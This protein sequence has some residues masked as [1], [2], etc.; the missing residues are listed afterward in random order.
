MKIISWNC[1]SVKARKEHLMLLLER[2]DPDVVL[3]QE[4]RIS[5]FPE[6]PMRYK[7]VHSE[8]IKGRNG[9]A[10]ITK[11]EMEFFTSDKEGRFIHVIINGIQF[12]CVYVP[13]GGSIS[14]SVAHKLQFF[15]YLRN[16][17]HVDSLIIGGD[18]NV[19]YK[20]NEFNMENPYTPIEQHELMYLEKYM[21]YETE[22]NLYLTWWD[23][24]ENRFNRNIGMGIDKIYCSKDLKCSPIKVLKYYRGLLLPS[25]HAPIMC[26]IMK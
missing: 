2:E 26:S 16:F 20:Q 19:L 21:N 13:N 15:Q 24:R 25:D 11:H 10:I 1:N 17:Y 8:A 18:F 14:S 6:L 9:V 3:I 4:T 12:I 7:V 23:Y 22:D 5:V